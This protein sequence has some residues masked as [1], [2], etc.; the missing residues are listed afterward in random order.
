[1]V[2]V[3]ATN[4]QGDRSYYSNYGNSVD[5]SAPGGDLRYE[6]SDGIA[7]TLNSGTTTQSSHN[8][9][10][11]QGTSMAAPHVSGLAALVYSVHGNPTPASVSQIITDTARP[12]PGSCSGGCGAGI[13]DATA[14][15]LAAKGLTPQNNNPLTADFSSSCSDLTCTFTNSSSGEGSITYSWVFGDGNSSSATNP[16]HTYSQAGTFGVTLV[17]NNGT[18]TSEATGEVTVSNPLANVAPTAG[19]MVTT[20]GLTASFTDTS[21]DSDGDIAEWHWDFGDGNTATAQNP[22]HTYGAAGSYTVILTVTDDD[23][24]TADVSHVVTVEEPVGTTELTID[25]ISPN[26]MPSGSIGAVTIYGSGFEPG[27]TISFI[28]GSGPTPTASDVVVTADTIN[29]TITAKDGGPRRNRIWDVVVTNPGGTSAVLPGG[30]T[31]TR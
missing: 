7:S 28:N 18:E 10:Y 13:A 29:A 16:T 25:S 19:Y 6:A 8:Y 3:A 26:T 30:L 1:V 23:N 17:A 4:R 15:V 11:Y 31:I 5:V 27:A 21:T 9:V 24:A 20:D 12:L 2:T 22:D 14:A